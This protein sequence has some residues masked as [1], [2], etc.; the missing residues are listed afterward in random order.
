LQLS[1]GLGTPINRLHSLFTRVPR[2]SPLGIPHAESCIAPVQKAENCRTPSAQYQMPSDAT[3]EARVML[4]GVH[5]SES[6]TRSGTLWAHHNSTTSAWRSMAFGGGSRDSVTSKNR[7][8][9]AYG[10]L[11]RLNVGFGT[12]SLKI[13]VSPVRI[14]VP[15]LQKVLQIAGK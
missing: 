11:W 10:A 14:R 8:D 15:P 13:M 5:R 1:Q 6:S 12:D 7:L 2:R 9:S 3:R 4:P